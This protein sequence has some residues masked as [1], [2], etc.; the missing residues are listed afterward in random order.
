MELFKSPT[1]NFARPSNYPNLL[2]GRLKLIDN[3]QNKKE[4][5]PNRAIRE[6]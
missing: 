5:S 1:V 3:I 2:K 6:G 4:G